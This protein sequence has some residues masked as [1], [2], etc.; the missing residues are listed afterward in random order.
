M[1][2]D[3]DRRQREAVAVDASVWVAASA[4]TG[5]TK[6]L[7]DRVLA[8]LL[9]GSA[10]HR[11][12]CLTFTKAAAA[13]MAN[14]LNQRL[15]LWATESD[16]ALGLEVAPLIDAVPD[17]D[18]VAAARRLFARVLDAPGG[19]RIATVHAFC[20]SLL[21]RFP[22]EAGVAP[23]FQ[24]MDER[25]ADEALAAAREAVL[26]AAREGG[27]ADLAAAL[28]AVTR[29]VPEAGFATLMGEL[30][31]H[32]A[33]LRRALAQGHA[34]FRDRLA[35][36]LGVSP[37]IGEAE[38]LTAACAPGAADE[39]ALAAAAALMQRSSRRDQEGGARIARW[40]ETP[41][42]RVAGFDEYC[43]AFF[44]QDG[45]QRVALLTKPL[46]RGEPAAAAALAAEAQRLEAVIAARAGAA[47][48]AASAALVRLGEALLDA[49]E[50]HKATLALLDY[51]DLVLR[52]RDLLRRPGVAPWVLFKLD[53]GIDHILID[54]AQDTNPEQW[55]VVEA[56][57][58]EFFTGA[59]ARALT[60]T[61]FAVGDAKQSIYSFQRADPEAFTRMR[62]HFAGRVT[63]AEQDWRVVDLDVSF[64]STDAV[65]A[66][67]DAIFARPE[68]SAG[69]AL[70][71]ALIRHQPFRA[72]HA[73]LVEM[74]PPVAPDPAPEPEPWSLPVEQH[75]ARPPPARLARV[76]AQTL[77]QWI[78]RGE[79]LPARD[80]AVRPGDVMVLV[81]RRGAFVG[82]LVRALKE[83]DVPVAGVDR[84]ILTEQLAVEDMIALG[85]FLLLPED[86]LTLAT[87]LK[88]PLFGFNEEMLF[89]LAYPRRG[90]LWEELHRRAGEELGF[91]AAAKTLGELL[92]RADFVP[93][94]EL[95]AEVLG[96]RGGRKAA[97]ARL[98]PEAADPLDEFLSLAL[99]YERVHEPSLERFLYWLAAGETEVKRDLD[100]RGRDEVRVLTVH[101]AKGLQAPIV[102]LPDTLQLPDQPA[103]LLWTESGLPLWRAHAR[104]GA[105]AAATAL[106][107]R[108]RREAAE[109][110]RLLYVALT[111]AEDRLYLC[112]WETRRK[113]GD[114]C[115]Y[116]LAEAGLAEA[117]GAV[118]VDFDF[119]A[120]AGA[121]GWRGRGWRIETPQ[122][123][124]PDLGERLPRRLDRDDA[125]PD[126]AGAPPPP[127]PSPPRPLAPSRP[128]EADPAARSPLGADAGAGLLRGRLVHRLL[129]R[130]P[131]LPPEA[132]LAAARRFLA[133]PVHG[134]A[135]TEQ[136]ALAAET[137]AVLDHADFAPLFG[138]SSQA[139]VPVVALLG[140]RALAGQID[141]LVV[142]DRDV[143]IVDYKTLRPPPTREQDV[144][145]PYLAQLAAYRA[146]IAAIY[147]SRAV[148]CALLWTEGPRLMPVSGALLDRHVPRD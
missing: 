28:A 88:G 133:L 79:R 43:E 143:L 49:Y 52:A 4:G 145:P 118:P 1:S 103:K 19:L 32:R 120:V 8:L 84:L 139:E 89:A 70:D 135:A 87:V 125:L 131:P 44:T 63:A 144:P 102:F 86:D 13:E 99:A 40:L 123:R 46:A 98:G 33:K 80:R 58:E 67:V 42:E 31:L 132:R 34:A 111:R 12:L 75:H 129:Q 119:T 57:A 51:D 92:A 27:D 140:G 59:G 83:A 62:E 94:Y 64:R 11:I 76:I 130:L 137:M 38:I 47:L 109:Y 113:P 96:A 141:R 108:Q 66:A 121:D 37:K 128:S 122:R 146:A 60:R 26:W 21:R 73:G 18:Q 55:E 41:A 105:P 142:G 116:R 74:W 29:H 36:A 50:Q 78:D 97:L 56:L 5:K 24:V 114:G 53:G 54:E 101:G 85:R 90:T 72:D 7:T 107:E 17:A 77:R 30:A 115:W 136:E 6:V 104:C 134:L 35:R 95:F 22:I 81:R 148:R 147:P 15:S 127:E 61:V 124:A 48:F 20:Q 65:L 82:E 93:P 16:A 45:P 117:P 106:A 39:R 112:G 71:G 10:P 25:S 9:A 23:H 69:V 2:A 68:A 138:P 14:R 100:Q 91:A 110:R 126:W 3:P